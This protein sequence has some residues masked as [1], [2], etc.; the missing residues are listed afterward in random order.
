MAEDAVEVGEFAKVVLFLL[1]ALFAFLGAAVSAE[2]IT[3]ALGGEHSVRDDRGRYELVLK[4]EGA[5]PAYPVRSE[6][7][8]T[9]FACLSHHCDHATAKA[10]VRRT[11]RKR[12]KAAGMKMAMVWWVVSPCTE[13]TRVKS[14]AQRPNLHSE[15]QRTRTH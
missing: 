8:L 11:T 15:S 7:G 12:R 4:R 9:V 10:A 3:G 14:Q 5:R 6:H 13:E 2:H 1:V